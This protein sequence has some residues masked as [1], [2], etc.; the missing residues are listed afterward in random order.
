MGVDDGKVEGL[1][2]VGTGSVTGE[3]SGI[4]GDGTLAPPDPREGEAQIIEGAFGTDPPV[5]VA[6]GDVVPNP[7]LPFALK[8]YSSPSANFRSNSVPLVNPND[9]TSSTK[10]LTTTTVGLLIAALLAILRYC[11]LLCPEE[12]GEHSSEME[13]VISKAI[14]SFT[15]QKT[16]LLY[17]IILS[18]LHRARYLRLSQKERE[19]QS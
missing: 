7:P 2:V 6:D 3:T 5:G 4:V 16:Q 9:I 11:F 13:R 8:R 14:V 1:L 10:A 18:D 15:M 12:D 19:R 17:E